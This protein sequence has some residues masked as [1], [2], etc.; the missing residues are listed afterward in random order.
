[1]S[2]LKQVSC[3]GTDGAAVTVANSGLDRVT[4]GGSSSITY[5]D[6]RGIRLTTVAST[7][8]VIGVLLPTPGKEIEGS[9]ELTTPTTVPSSGF[10]TLANYLNAGGSGRFGIGYT[11]AKKIILIGASGPLAVISKNGSSAD[12]TVEPN[13]KIRV[14]FQAKVGTSSSDGRFACHIYTPGSTS[15]LFSPNTITNANLGTDDIA[16]MRCG[17]NSASGAFVFGARYIQIS[18]AH[19][20]ELAEW[21][22]AAPLAAVPNLAATAKEPSTV[23][24]S[25]GKITVTWDAVSGADHYDLYW[26]P[27]A[28]PTSGWTKIS[29]A[30]S[31][32]EIAVPAGVYAIDVQPM[33]AA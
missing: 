19:T 33:V 15:P 5:D 27:G 23:G 25:D 31:G 12:G 21:I 6:A 9:V 4:A 16:E 28:E 7:T 10:V 3:L 24:G 11:S 17:E 32:V 1:M 30:T 13:T 14:A 2:F 22:P 18:D 29:K 26:A 20:G 8:T